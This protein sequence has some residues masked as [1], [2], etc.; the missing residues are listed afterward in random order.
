MRIWEPIRAFDSQ[1]MGDKRGW[2]LANVRQG[3]NIP[4]GRY[5]SCK[6]DLEAQLKAKTAHAFR[7]LPQGASV[8]IYAIAKIMKVRT[9]HRLYGYAFVITDKGEIY[10]DGH[11]KS[12]KWLE[13]IARNNHLYWGEKC[14]GVR[15][16]KE[17]R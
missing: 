4:A 8:P 15:I 13:D 6:T 11:R 14:D 7:T 1:K 12:R 9:V 2:A 16:V 10:A 5:A 3:F 17:V